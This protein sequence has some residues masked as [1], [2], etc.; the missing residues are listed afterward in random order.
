MYTF[1][2]TSTRKFH[3][4]F[5]QENKSGVRRGGMGRGGTHKEGQIWGNVV[6]LMS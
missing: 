2:I 3:F 6:V 5:I 1:L 4:L